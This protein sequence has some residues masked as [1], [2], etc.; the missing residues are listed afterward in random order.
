MNSPENTPKQ[1]W[2]HRQ[3]NRREALVIT[4]GALGLFGTVYGAKCL[5]YQL[6]ANKEDN[7]HEEFMKKPEHA[8]ILEILSKNKIKF[9]S[10]HPEG[11]DDENPKEPMFLI[12]VLPGTKS[13]TPEEREEY[14]ANRRNIAFSATNLLVFLY[15]KAAIEEVHTDAYPLGIGAKTPEKRMDKEQL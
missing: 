14:D 1:P 15:E 10:Y 5:Y 12:S 7:E 4:A 8:R 13:G 11:A 3:V 2:L 9:A 6:L